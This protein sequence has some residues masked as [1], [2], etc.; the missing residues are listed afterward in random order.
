MMQLDL[1]YLATIDQVAPLTGR[2]WGCSFDGQR[3]GLVG[4]ALCKRDQL[5]EV[6]PGFWEADVS[7]VVFYAGQFDGCSITR[8]VRIFDQITGVMGGVGLSLYIRGAL[9]PR[10]V[11]VRHLKTL[12]GRHGVKLF[13]E[14]QGRW[15][16][17]CEVIA[18]V[19]DDQGEG[20]IRLAGE[21]EGRPERVMLDEEM[22]LVDPDKKLTPVQEAFIYGLGAWS[23][24]ER[25]A[26]YHVGPSK[27]FVY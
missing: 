12:G 11:F 1:D 18:A 16:E 9:G 22:G 17:P 27:F 21:F 24:K 5:V 15:F 7:P 25:R 8:A 14:G 20:V 19:G 26:K 4:Y 3:L 6:R 10:E 23:C 13:S 2:R